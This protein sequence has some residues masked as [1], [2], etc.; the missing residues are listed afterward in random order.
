MDRERLRSL[1]VAVIGGGWSDE[2]EISLESA[3]RCHDALVEAGFT[4]V[5]TLDLAA[6]DFMTRL[7]SGGYDVA[8]VAMHGAYGE[9]GCVQGLLEVLHLPYTFSGVA[10]SAV[11]SEKQ[12]A[13]AVFESAG[14][15]TPRG[16]DVPAGTALTAEQV[17]E[18]VA[19]LGLPLFVKPAA[20]GSSFGITRVTEASAVNDAIATASAAGGRVLVEECVTGMEITVPV[21]GND[22]AHAL[23]VVEIVTGADFY[24]VTVKY[25]PSALHHVIPARLEPGVYARAQDLAVRAHR[26]LGCRGC[27]RSDFIV[28]AEGEPVILETNTIPGMTAESLLPDSARHGGID[29]PE[30]CTRFIEY[31]LE[32]SEGSC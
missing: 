10:A 24:D 6:R 21:V 28:T 29:F 15:R 8:F 22:D 32:G 27:S 1:H 2:R 19:K 25:E 13:K 30:L 26:A 17:D 23:P 11:S 4:R 3:S 16:V 31:A 7:V 9:D 14:I 18:L 20:N 12:L 5:D